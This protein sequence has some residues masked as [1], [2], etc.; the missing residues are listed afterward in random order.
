M[1]GFEK[2]WNDAIDLEK[3]AYDEGFE[4]GKEDAY[5]EGHVDGE[6]FGFRTGFQLGFETSFINTIL[7]HVKSTSETS[8]DSVKKEKLVKAIDVVLSQI[9]AMPN[10]IDEN[11]DYALH[12]NRIRYQLKRLESMDILIK[13]A[14][15]LIF[16]EKDNVDLS[17]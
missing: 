17:F 4:K 2:A 3:I 13:K 14:V 16:S 15:S 11:F 5:K 12:F 1:E 9:K 10:E 7:L 8:E 6:N